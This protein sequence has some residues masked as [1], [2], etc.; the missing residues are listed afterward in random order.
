MLENVDD[1]L[2]IFAVI[3]LI[4][5]AIAIA[6]YFINLKTIEK[7]VRREVRYYDY[8]RKKK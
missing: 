7:N 4:V 8:E 2:A 6:L 3:G 5:L 1:Y